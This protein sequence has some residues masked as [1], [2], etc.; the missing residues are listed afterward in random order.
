[1]IFIDSKI[2]MYL[3]GVAQ[4]HK[5]EAQVL[6][7]RFIAAGQLDKQEAIGPAGSRRTAHASRRAAPSTSL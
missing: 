5:A 2:P 4:P 6:L 3:L 1:L 7:E